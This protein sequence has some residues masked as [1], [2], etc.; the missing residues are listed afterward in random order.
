MDEVIFLTLAQEHDIL[1]LN[2]TYKPLIGWIVFQM[3]KNCCQK[4]EKNPLPAS[5]GDILKLLILPRQM[6]SI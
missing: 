4:L 3:E 5:Q 6:Y 2:P 1:T